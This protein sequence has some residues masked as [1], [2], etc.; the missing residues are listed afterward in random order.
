G[1]EPQRVQVLDD[2][3]YWGHTFLTAAFPVDVPAL[4]YSVVCV[5]D[6]AAEVGL[7]EESVWEPWGG[8]GGSGRQIQEPDYALDNDLVSARLDPGSGGLV[9]LLDKRSGTEWIPPGQRAGIFQ[10]CL[11]ENQGMTAWTIGRF[12]ERR[13]LV[14]GGKLKRL[15]TGPW[16][17]AWQWTREL[18]NSKLKLDISLR[19]GSPRVEFRLEVDWRQI[20]DAER[21]IPHLKVRFPLSAS[22]PVGRYEI[23]FGAIDR[24]LTGGEE[25]P[26]L[27][28]AEMVAD[29]GAGVVL[30][31]TS[32]YGFNIEGDSLNMTLLRGSIDPDPLP[33][34][35]DHVIE[36]A[37]APHGEGWAAA[38]SV[39]EGEQAN[40]PLVV[41]SCDFQSGDL[42]TSTSYVT[43]EHGG[44]RLVA[45]KKSQDDDAVILRLAEVNGE[46]SEVSLTLGGGIVPAGAQAVEVDAMERPVAVS[47]ARLEGE[48][49]KVRLPAHGMTA[50]RLGASLAQIDLGP[51]DLPALGLFLRLL[52]VELP[53]DLD[54]HLGVRIQGGVHLLE[55]WKV[56]LHLGDR[57]LLSR[58][59]I[60]GLQDLGVQLPD[61]LAQLLTDAL[62]A[63]DGPGHGDARAEEGQEGDELGANHKLQHAPLSS[64]GYPPRVGRRRLPAW[65]WKDTLT[66]PPAT[67]SHKPGHVRGSPCPQEVS[68]VA[69]SRSASRTA[70]PVV[71]SCS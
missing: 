70:S 55:V 4:G 6:R 21:G 42:P 52:G 59:G 12:L 2:G 9:G 41:G 30:T 20:G 26:A 18:G 34:L 31:N 56:A 46:A 32:K 19:H 50:V 38:D 15:H 25:V 68:A 61:H 8:A 71:R 64:D 35:G 67:H 65:T 51:A 57:P 14:S 1:V 40:L 63:H 33:D 47:S 66:T 29:D 22:G 69:T 10:Y 45:V 3:F 39:R 13:D 27:R 16:L 54:Q 24:D 48:T 44:V 5:S 17:N 60:L 36:Y 58:D 7:K 62:A 23:P 37:L 11:E 43:L 49:L 53:L 28:W